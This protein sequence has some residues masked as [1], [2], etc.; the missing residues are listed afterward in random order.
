MRAVG[1]C[2]QSSYR[3]LARR[4][5]PGLVA[6]PSSVATRPGSTPA[7]LRRVDRAAGRKD[8]RGDGRPGSGLRD[9]RQS[10][11]FPRDTVRAT[12]LVTARVAT[13]RSR[14]SSIGGARAEAI[15]AETGWYASN[16]GGRRAGCGTCAGLARLPTIGRPP[17]ATTPG[18][19]EVSV[20]TLMSPGPGMTRGSRA[21]ALAGSF[22]RLWKGSQRRVT[23][24]LS[25]KREPPYRS[26]QTTRKGGSR[27]WSTDHPMLGSPGTT[28]RVDAIA[29]RAGSAASEC[30]IHPIGGGSKGGAWDR[31]CSSS[32]AGARDPG[33]DQPEG[34]TEM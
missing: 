17:V 20:P 6:A 5:L 28:R 21:R 11:C 3:V 16:P 13:G 29:R 12:N 31:Y 14:S 32:D 15:M 22:L 24:F 2:Y 18:Q 8:V 33:R 23:A 10:S 19:T 26:F 27:L 34:Q 1:T 25:L 7:P 4:R 9:C 30:R